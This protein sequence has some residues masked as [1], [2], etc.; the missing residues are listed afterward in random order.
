MT[1]IPEGKVAKRYGVCKRTLIRW[2]EHPEVGFPRP[3]WI[4]DRKYRD[5]E[6]LDAFDADRVRAS[7][8]ERPKPRENR[9]KQLKQFADQSTTADKAV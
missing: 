8:M 1:L 6:L 9:L 2:D 4:N 7:M 3:V 5:A